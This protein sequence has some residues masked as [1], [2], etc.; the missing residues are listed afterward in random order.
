MTLGVVE[1]GEIDTAQVTSCRVDQLTQQN[2]KTLP[3]I[4]VC[5]RPT[6]DLPRL[7]GEEVWYIGADWHGAVLIALAVTLGGRLETEEL[8]P[9]R[10]EGF[11]QPQRH[12][13]SQHRFAVQEI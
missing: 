6:F 3:C 11:L 4:D 12:P 10:T 13:G 2:R 7:D 8:L 5:T 1:P 9:V